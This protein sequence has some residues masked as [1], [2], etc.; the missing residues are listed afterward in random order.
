MTMIGL[1][2]PYL[3][4]CANQEVTFLLTRNLC[5]YYLRME[6]VFVSFE[7]SNRLSIK[8]TLIYVAE[9]CESESM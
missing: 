5:P 2:F 1:L 9:H 8:Q 3:R 7:C 4:H 6:F